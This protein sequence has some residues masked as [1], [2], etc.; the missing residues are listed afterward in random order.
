MKNWLKYNRLSLNYNKTT[1]LLITKKDKIENSNFNIFINKVEIKRTDHVKY[2][3]IYID[4]KMNWSYLIN[5]LTQH[6]RKSIGLIYSRNLGIM[7]MKKLQKYYTMLLFT[8]I[9]NMK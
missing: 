4:Y 2:L 7:L 5:Q 1:Y 8:L 6:L 9:F 3:G